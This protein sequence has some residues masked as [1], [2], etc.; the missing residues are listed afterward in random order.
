MRLLAVA[1]YVLL[2]AQGIAPAESVTRGARRWVNSLG[3]EMVRIEL[4]GFATGSTN[5]FTFTQSPESL[6]INHAGQPLAT[7]VFRDAK[8][9]RPFF[10][11]VHAPGGEKV[12]RNHPPIAGVDAGDHD[13]MHPGIWMAFGD[14]NGQDF[15]R[16][17]GRI[18]H[19]R[20]TQTPTVERGR[21][22]FAAESRVRAVDGA[23]LCA[24][25]NCFTLAQL[26]N[27]WLLVWDAT[28]R[29]EDGDLTFGDQ[30]EMGFGARVA[31]GITEKNGGVILNSSGLRS[32]KGTWG[33]PADWCDYSGSVAD[34]LAGITLMADPGNFRPC[35]WHN[36]DYG[37][38]VANPFGREAMKQGSKS[39]VTVK[40]GETIRLRFG[41]A[42]HSAHATSASDLA[43]YYRDFLGE[44]G[45]S[46]G[47]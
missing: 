23:S 12:T 11:N 47:Q 25:T 38:M 39:S 36:R 44:L 34:R 21:L 13:T 20:F 33:R 31:T 41:A 46:R 22:T 6:V 16:N 8:I 10:A 27:A 29:S 37:L 4:G 17:K 3:T 9:L 45:A 14:I 26:T 5:G 1:S 40:R 43:A 28:F 35:W 2:L 42:I 32:A 24:L 30:E 19:V 18:E 15:W 7:Y